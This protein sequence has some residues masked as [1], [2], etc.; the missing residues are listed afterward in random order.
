[1]YSPVA[2]F[3]RSSFNRLYHRAGMVI[4][5]CLV[6][7]S[8]AIIPNR[9]LCE[10]PPDYKLGP[11]DVIVVDV[12]EHQELSGEYYIPSDGFINMKR[13][14]RIEVT[15]KTLSEV[16]GLVVE[17]LKSILIEPDVTVTLKTPRPQ[18]VHI[19]G[20]VQKPG[21]YDVKPGW[22]IMEAISAAGGIMQGIG[23]SDCKASILRAGTGVKET[24]TIP[25]VMRGS[26]TA[27]LPIYPGDVISIES[28][29]L[30]PVYVMG[31]VEHPGL[32]NLR[33]DSAGVLEAITV[34]GG[35]KDNAVLSKV[36]ITHLAGDNETVNILPAV[37]EGKNQSSIKLR[38]GDLVV[39]P[40]STAKFAVLGWVNSPGIF[41]LKEGQ[42]IT[43]ADALGMAGG[44]DNKRGGLGRV[45][46]VR[47]VNGKEERML[48]DISK[49][50]KTAD[51][52]QNPEIQ[53]ADIVWVPE[54]GSPDWDKVLS[55]I[56]S[57]LS[58]LWLVR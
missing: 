29:E 6:I 1:M 4:F 48:F 36:S 50:T 17:Q 43:L 49:F 27:N 32:Y 16:S 22:R 51:T 39:V 34:A 15:G 9:A 52:S 42:K 11:E 35:A 13:G 8:I 20:V 28:V 38:S 2:G 3:E 10:Q 30:I 47:K 5:A 55:G 45:A 41:A 24:V 44:I 18:L 7:L 12:I 40:E 57:G 31:E 23:T 21:P 46:I 53:P 54:S 14:G 37:Q 26:E 58:F 25:D 56:S 19:V 33:K